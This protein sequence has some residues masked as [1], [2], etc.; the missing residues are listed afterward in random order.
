MP[1][2]LA[3]YHVLGSTVG[4][5]HGRFNTYNC[6]AERLSVMAVGGTVMDDGAST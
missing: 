1:T 6:G 5:G 3:Q 4:G 2:H